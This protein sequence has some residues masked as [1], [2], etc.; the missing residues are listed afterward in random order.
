M[1]ATPPTY[2]TIILKLFTQLDVLLKSY[3]FNGYGALT[4]TLKYPLG[5]AIT[6]YIVLLGISIS[7]GWV[8]LSMGNL[9]KST[10]KIGLLYTF[11]MNWGFFSEY[12]IKLISGGAND[13]GGILLNATPISLP[14]FAGEGINGAMQS[15]LIEFTKIGQWI[16]DMGTW[17]S[18]GPYFS[19][20]I[21]WGFGDVLILIA[22]FEI[23]LAKIMLAILFATAPLF[24]SFTLFKATQGFFERWLGAIVGFALLIIFVSATLALALSIAQ[25]AIADM[26]VNHATGIS[27]VGFV[28]VIVVGF[29]GIGII[30]RVSHLAQQIGGIVTISSGTSLIAGAIGGALAGSFTAVRLPAGVMG[31]AGRLMRFGG[32]KSGNAESTQANVKSIQRDLVIGEK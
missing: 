11:A 15:V 18:P 12:A 13:I 2:T 19:A 32:L 26:Y 30:L 5:L 20:L 17:H 27:F 7:H 22:V 21:T 4:H 9:I 1:D 25:W 23:A 8:R 16:W 28:P 6:L 29:L 3:I 31:R 24:V 10:L 14:H